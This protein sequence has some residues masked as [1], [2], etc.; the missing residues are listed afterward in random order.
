ML[1]AGLV[2]LGITYL[3]LLAS[4]GVIRETLAPLLRWRR[5]AGLILSRAGLCVHHQ[6]H[7]H[8]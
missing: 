8:M 3:L 1:G 2:F 7:T 4:S 6:M 5:P